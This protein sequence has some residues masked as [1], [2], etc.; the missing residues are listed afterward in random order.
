MAFTRVDFTELTTQQ[1]FDAVLFSM[2]LH[3]SAS[4]TQFFTQAASLLNATGVLVLV[5]LCAHDQAWARDV[6]V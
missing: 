5:E 6:C 2:V 3:H 1:R 4:P